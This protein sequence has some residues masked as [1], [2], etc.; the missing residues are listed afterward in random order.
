MMLCYKTKEVTVTLY[1]NWY[2]YLKNRNKEIE[3]NIQKSLEGK[4][5]KH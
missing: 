3:P 2:P 4:L 5:S 1:V